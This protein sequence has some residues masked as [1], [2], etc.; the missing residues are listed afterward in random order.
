MSTNFYAEYHETCKCC[1]N[2]TLK[3]VHIGKRSIGWAFTFNSMDGEIVSWDEWVEF[4]VQK[5]ARI[6]DEYNTEY[7]IFN[8]ISVVCDTKHNKTPPLH[9]PLHSWE[10]DKTWYD[11]DGWKFNNYEFS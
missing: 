11:P 8:L 2:S 5:L 3:R 10:R 1:G 4:L 9:L 6:K 7:S